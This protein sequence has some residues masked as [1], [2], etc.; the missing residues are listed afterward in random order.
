MYSLVI[1]LRLLQL[2][3]APSLLHWLCGA[4]EADGGRLAS[5]VRA[6]SFGVCVCVCIE[7]PIRRPHFAE[8][9]LVRAKRV[10]RKSLRFRSTSCPNCDRCCKPSADRQFGDPPRR[11][12]SSGLRWN[13]CLWLVS[14][15]IAM[16]LPTL[17]LVLMSITGRKSLACLQFVLE[18]RRGL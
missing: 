15:S 8:S 9:F 16:R 4:A 11:S 5:S 1:L 6:I 18:Q 14:G 17:V 3:P 2:L 10:T 12:T 13:G 7:H